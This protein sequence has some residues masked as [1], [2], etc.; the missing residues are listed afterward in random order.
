MPSPYYVGG[1]GIPYMMGMGGLGYGLGASM[2]GMGMGMGMGMNTGMLYPYG[3]AATNPYA[4]TGMLIAEL[5][6]WQYGIGF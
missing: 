2:Y 1:L 6:G 5:T 4:Y 3:M